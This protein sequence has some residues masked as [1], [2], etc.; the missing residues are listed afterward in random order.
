MIRATF[1]INF[2]VKWKK[3][4]RNGEAPIYLRIT[5]NKQ[6][7]EASLKRSIKPTLWDVTR[8][9]A[10]GNSQEALELNDYI[11]S[12]RAQ[13]FHYQKEIQEAGKELS[14]KAILNAFLGIGEKKWSLVELFTQHNQNMQNTYR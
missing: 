12:I 1:S 3:L 9:K 6:Q 13:I 2:F 4:L 7:A 8:N 10:K 14:A 11:N 5:V